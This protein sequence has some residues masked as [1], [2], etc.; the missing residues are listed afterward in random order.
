MITPYYS[1]DAVTLYHGDCRE[2]LPQ[3]HIKADC[4]IA[5]PPYEETSLTWDRWP[6]G[7][8]AT[9]ADA[10]NSLWCFGSL[11]MFG[12]QWDSFVDYGWK[13]SHDAIG[14]HETD[15]SVWEKHNASGPN[16]DRFRRVH[17]LIAHWYL[18]RWADVYRNPQRITTGVIERGRVV[19]QGAKDIDH[20]GA[21]RTGSWTDDGTRLMHS[22]IR[23]RSMHRKN[24]IHRTEKPIDLLTPLIKYACPP[25]GL[26]LDPCAGSCS[27]G[28][29][30]RLSG[31]R[32]VLIEAD[33]AMCEKAAKFRLGVE[34]S[35]VNP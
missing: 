31:R 4:A 14:E 1:D 19:T 26:V 30:A 25:G 21:Y 17:E 15:I 6:F 33:E 11:R 5:D 29:A 32:A 23:A 34:L 12:R 13:L 9:V 18:G 8:T 27:T 2:I 10:T 3:L 28:V 22:I 35:G 20:R 24:P 7:W 16:A